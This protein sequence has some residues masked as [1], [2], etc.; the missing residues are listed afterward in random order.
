M[1]AHI[2]PGAVIA[3]ALQSV[4]TG[5]Q[6]LRVLVLVLSVLSACKSKSSVPPG[7]ST[8]L[9]AVEIGKKTGFIDRA[10]KI[11]IPPN[12]EATG[13]FTSDGLAWVKLDHRYGFIDK[14]GKEVIQRQFDKADSFSEGMAPFNVGGKWG[15]IDT[16]GKIAINPI[17]EQAELFSQS[18]A[19]VKT[20]DK[21]GF[22][23][24]NG[25]AIIEP[26][27]DS[28]DQFDSGRAEV[29]KVE[30]RFPN[31]MP[32]TRLCGYID[33][34][35][36]EVVPL[37]DSICGDFSEGLASV[38][39][40]KYSDH[41]GYIDTSGKFVIN[42]TYHDVTEFSEGVAAVVG[43]D[44]HRM[45]IDKTGRE[46]CTITET[47]APNGR[48]HLGLA[49]VEVPDGKFGFIDKTCK[50]VIS[51]LEEASDFSN[52]L[53]FATRNGQPTYIDPSGKSIWTG[54]AE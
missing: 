1:K 30:G 14:A 25:K 26:K 51:G 37:R 5:R 3:R 27:Y 39:V 8:P 28:V 38:A 15:F 9:F 42:P 19:A 12:Y 29:M 18:R 22:V 23:D 54:T 36:V 2:V 49:V 16:S 35:G 53:A 7:D 13:E 47:K 33:L 41:I 32:K 48:F 24:R 45:L 20:G 52:G 34:Q 31:G 4:R 44:D 43:D 46:I 21:W 50:V 6:M 10:G 11:A 40:G 17:Y